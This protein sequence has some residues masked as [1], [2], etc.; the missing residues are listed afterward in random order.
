MAIVNKTDTDL[1]LPLPPIPCWARFFI[2]GSRDWPL[3]F[4]LTSSHSSGVIATVHGV[5]SRS[6]RALHG[7]KEKQG[8]GWSSTPEASPAQ[9]L[10]CH[11]PHLK[12]HNNH[13]KATS[14]LLLIS[15]GQ[16]FN[17]PFASATP[18]H[19]LT[20]F[21]PILH[22]E[23]L[24]LK[25][26]SWNDRARIWIQVWWPGTKVCTLFITLNRLAW[27]I[28]SQSR[29]QRAQVIKEIP[30]E[31]G[32]ETG[33]LGKHWLPPSFMS[34]IVLLLH[35]MLLPPFQHRV[36]D[37]WEACIVV[38]KGYKWGAHIGVGSGPTTYCVT[39]GKPLNPSVSQPS[40]L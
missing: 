4:P 7:R 29:L 35:L 25:D 28:I 22:T 12:W 34:V 15:T 24:K 26:T 9:S 18:W 21:V 16:Y 6:R 40:Q 31:R 2:P 23:N 10:M 37:T 13:G 32:S 20:I 38:V 36:L 1:G 3:F 8:S 19:R 17:R 30:R 39:L 14:Y 33:W 11:A 27:M 5:E